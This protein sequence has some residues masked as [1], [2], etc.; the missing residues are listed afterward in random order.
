VSLRKQ[1]RE[2]TRRAIADAARDLLE[3]HGAEALTFRAIAERA[4]VSVGTVVNHA[5]N[6]ARLVVGL[7]VEDLAGVMERTR[8]LDAQAPLLDQLI[9]RFRG[10]F[11][12]YAARPALAR[13]TI[14]EVAFAPDDAY[15][16]YLE[17]T[18]RFVTE[19]AAWL[20]ED[21]RLHP[22]VPPLVAARVLFDTY[23]GVIVLFLR[24]DQPDIELG[25]AAL[26]GSFEPLLPV[27]FVP[28]R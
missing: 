2:A 19:L 17:L 7:L 11:G 3:E 15:T 27:L 18:V 4:Q 10:F 28:A 6:K 23:I 8:T 24:E 22:H 21:G 9:E 12:V 26:R 16:P 13:R 5:G 20:Q 25:L 1:Q 14:L